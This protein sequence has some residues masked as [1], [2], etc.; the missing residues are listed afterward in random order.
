MIRKGH[1]KSGMSACIGEAR[2]TINTATIQ[3]GLHVQRLF[4]SAVYD[5]LTRTVT[6][7]HISY[8]S[9]KTASLSFRITQGPV[10][11]FR[12]VQGG[13]QIILLHPHHSRSRFISII[14]IIQVRFSRK[15]Q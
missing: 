7:N 10:L 8:F 12:Q 9:F 4:H 11:S 1:N 15:P 2:H 6:R 5:A 14:S 3:R 13:Q